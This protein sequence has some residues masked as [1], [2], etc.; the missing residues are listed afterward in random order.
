[1]WQLWGGTLLT[2]GLLMGAITICVRL[3]RRGQHVGTRQY[4]PA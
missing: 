1:M 3:L 2:M 4:S